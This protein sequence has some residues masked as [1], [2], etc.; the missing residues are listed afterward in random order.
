MDLKLKSVIKVQNKF[1]EIKNQLATINT[2]LSK[3]KDYINNQMIN[4]QHMWYLISKKIY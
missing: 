1:R 4:L 2:D 3:I